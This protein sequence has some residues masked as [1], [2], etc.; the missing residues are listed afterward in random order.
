MT[1]MAFQKLAFASVDRIVEVWPAGVR[2][3]NLP[4]LAACDKAEAQL[5]EY[6]LKCRKTGAYNMANLKYCT[7]E[8]MASTINMNNFV[9]NIR[10]NK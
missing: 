5:N 9:N 7:L 4:N 6:W 8:N 1:E 3:T 10:G 2:L